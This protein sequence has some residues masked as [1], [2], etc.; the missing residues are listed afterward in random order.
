MI[1]SIV[2]CVFKFLLL[3]SIL[4]NTP[5]STTWAENAHVSSPIVPF[6][7]EFNYSVDIKGDP[8]PR[9]PGSDAGALDSRFTAINVPAGY[10]LHVTRVTGDLV[11]WIIGIPQPGSKAGILWGL[12]PNVP[13]TSVHWSIPGASDSCFVYVQ[14]ALSAN[15][16]VIRIPVDQV[17][18]AYLPDDV[19]IS[20]LSAWMNTTG[21]PI[22]MEA[23]FKLTYELVPVD[24]RRGPF[25]MQVWAPW[26][27]R[28]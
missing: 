22:H 5:I 17:V 3:L 11:A 8:D 24:P 18:D 14:G 19:L 13:D 4:G 20:R 21:A 27:W 16:D 6:S 9:V 28:L 25:F 7:T 23:T 15:H 1:K 10:R 2:S 12:K 26:W